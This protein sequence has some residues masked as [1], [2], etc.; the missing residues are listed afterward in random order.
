M[1]NVYCLDLYV[2]H[3]WRQAA[4]LLTIYSVSFFHCKTTLTG[5]IIQ[6]LEFILL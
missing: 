5:Q 2:I 1:Y 6:K 3:V 4:D